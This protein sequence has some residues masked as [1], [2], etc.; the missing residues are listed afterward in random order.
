MDNTAK[1]YAFNHTRQAFL[2]TELEIANTHW[3]RL[4][5]LMGTSSSN[6]PC[7]RGLWIVPCHGVHTIA[8]RY[9]VDVVFLDK[10]NVV[11]HVE[12]NLKP[13]R[14]TPVR[15]DAATVLEVPSRT[16][17]TTGTS[18]GDQIEIKFNHK[19]VAK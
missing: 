11:V 9:P 16:V 6:F 3:R 1:G 17:Y 13:W 19:D 10:D 2:A 14:L 4:M 7:G 15:L 5:G 12:E 8:M 18:P